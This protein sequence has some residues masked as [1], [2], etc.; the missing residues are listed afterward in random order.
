MPAE[1]KKF[2]I[3]CRVE[4]DGRKGKV[5]SHYS[6]YTVEVEWDGRGPSLVST[7]VL[8]KLKGGKK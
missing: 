5:I 4:F 8:K 2:P 7:T 6:L 1:A 3:G